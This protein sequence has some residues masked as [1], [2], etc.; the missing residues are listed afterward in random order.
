MAYIEIPMKYGGK[1]IEYQNLGGMT[2]MKLIYELFLGFS[3]VP[4]S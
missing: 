1:F 4:G 2:L 3:R